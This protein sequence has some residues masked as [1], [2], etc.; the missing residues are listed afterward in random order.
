MAKT[1]VKAIED[2]KK[3]LE[4]LKSKSKLKLHRSFCEYYEEM[5]YLKQ[6]GNFQFEEFTSSE[7]AQS[8]ATVMHK[9]I[10]MLKFL[11]SKP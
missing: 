8:L 10:L 6:S 4:K 11:Q 2:M 1:K 9:A 7:K 5:N 3:N